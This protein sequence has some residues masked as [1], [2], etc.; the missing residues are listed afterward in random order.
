MDINIPNG[1]SAYVVASPGRVPSPKSMGRPS[2][3]DIRYY[4]FIYIHHAVSTP[5]IDLTKTLAHEVSSNM[6][7]RKSGF[8]SAIF[9]S[10]SE[11]APQGAMGFKSV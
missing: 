2:I 10:H 5:Y 6:S 4:L 3:L 7:T 1:E 8:T 9:L 11:H